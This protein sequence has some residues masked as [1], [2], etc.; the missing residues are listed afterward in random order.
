MSPM[1]EKAK[2]LLMLGVLN[3]VFG[4][5]R[6]IVYYLQ[7]FVYSHPDWVQDF[8]KMGL[9]DILNAARELERL[10]LEKMDSLKKIAES[11]E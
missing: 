8:E 7:D 11:K 5:A 4:D 3:D 9:Y 6:N 10:A 2:A 1:D